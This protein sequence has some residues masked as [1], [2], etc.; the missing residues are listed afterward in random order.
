MDQISRVRPNTTAQ[1]VQHTSVFF[2]KV[3][4]LVK[5]AT[6]DWDLLDA[7]DYLSGEVVGWWVHDILNKLINR[8]PRV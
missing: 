6:W 2:L 1:T 8:I 7:L 3:S 5:P 4:T